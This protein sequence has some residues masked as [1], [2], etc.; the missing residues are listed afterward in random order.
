ML[1]VVVWCRF[2][3]HEVRTDPKKFPYLLLS[4]KSAWIKCSVHSTDTQWPCNT[5]LQKVATKA[6]LAPLFQ[7]YAI[8]IFVSGSSSEPLCKSSD[9]DYSSC[10]DVAR[11]CSNPVGPWANAE[12]LKDIG[13]SAN[14]KAES[15]GVD[16][17]WISYDDFNPDVY[18]DF[19]IAW[20]GGGAT[21]AHEIGHYLGLL[22]TFDGEY[23]CDGDGYDYGDKVPD[24]AASESAQTFSIYSQKMYED[25]SQWCSSFREG[26]QPDPRSLLQYNTCNSGGSVVG[27]YIDPIFNVMNYPPDVCCMTFTPGQV[28]RMQQMVTVYRSKMVAKYTV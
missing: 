21:V 28:T 8:N 17:V 20:D 27:D 1:I 13:V 7:S 5:C 23:T 19:D 25:L 15:T 11:G 22:H 14:W 12:M 2:K 24:T 9:K 6:E 16:W 10:A 26:E 3:V 4:T 18:N